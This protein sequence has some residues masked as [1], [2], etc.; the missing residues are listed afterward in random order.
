M[1]KQRRGSWIPWLPARA[2]AVDRVVSS[3]HGSTVYRLHNSKGYV[4]WAIHARSKGSGRLHATG[5]GE[6]AGVRRRAVEGSPA[7]ACLAAQ[8]AK[9][10]ARGLYMK[11]G[12]MRA[13]LGGQGSGAGIHSGRYRKGRV[14]LAD[15]PVRRL[16]RAR[17]GKMGGGNLAHHVKK[18]RASSQLKGRRQRR[19]STT[20]AARA[21]LRRVGTQAPNVAR[22]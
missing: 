6:H 10:C 3:S 16:K 1:P 14:G 13:N 9:T 12:S 22:S 5:G 11:L 20:E 2:C 21:A 19:G 18:R 7:R 17:K 8:D 15:E 4:I